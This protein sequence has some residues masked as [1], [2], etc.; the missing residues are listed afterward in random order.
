MQKNI[1]QLVNWEKSYKIVKSQLS[2]NVL[3]SKMIR[4]EL[5]KKDTAHFA[6]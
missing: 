2:I 4:E 1:N 5:I 6:T 3:A